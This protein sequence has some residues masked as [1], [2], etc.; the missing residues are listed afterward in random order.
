VSYIQDAIKRHDPSGTKPVQVVWAEMVRAGTWKIPRNRDGSG[1]LVPLNPTTLERYY[2]RGMFPT[3]REEL[4][5]LG[6]LP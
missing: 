4:D 1:P 6:G 3:Y 5:R 2:P